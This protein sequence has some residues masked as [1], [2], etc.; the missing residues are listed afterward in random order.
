MLGVMPVGSVSTRNCRDNRETPV[1][2]N[3]HAATFRTLVSFT[4]L[5]EMEEKGW[6]REKKNNK[7]SW[8][9]S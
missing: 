4:E 8:V 9:H 6:E 7:D 3:S 5:G 1:R 2:N